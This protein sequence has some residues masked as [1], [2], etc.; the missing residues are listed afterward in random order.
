MHL[1]GAIA[2]VFVLF[3]YLIRSSFTVN[4]LCGYIAVVFLFTLSFCLSSEISWLLSFLIILMAK[5]FFSS[6]VYCST[7]IL[8]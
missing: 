3:D 6:I 4:V 1:L 2:V 7:N 5:E 8:G